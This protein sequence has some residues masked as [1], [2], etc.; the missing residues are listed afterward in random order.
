MKNGGNSIGVASAIYEECSF[1]CQGFVN[2]KF[3]HCPREANQ[4]AHI[5]ACNS[6]VSLTN[7]RQLAGIFPFLS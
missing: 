5:L 6:N 7:R 4:I 3:D 1:L 2:V